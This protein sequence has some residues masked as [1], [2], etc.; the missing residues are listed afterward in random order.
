MKVADRLN[1]HPIS[2]TPSYNNQYGWQNTLPMSATPPFN[3]QSG[4]LN[5]QPMSATPSFNNQSGWL[6]TH[7]LSAL[8]TMMKKTVQA[9]AKLAD[10]ANL[11]LGTVKRHR[12]GIRSMNIPKDIPQNI[13]DIIAQLP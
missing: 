11:A 13:C 8:Q 5:T 10:C 1:K 4:W 3:N 7:P 9:L 6:N 2:A 12:G